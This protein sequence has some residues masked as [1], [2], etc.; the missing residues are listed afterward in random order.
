MRK[1][2]LNIAIIVAI[3]IGV[4]C[5]A[6]SFATFNNIE[7]HWAKDV[8]NDFAEKGYINSESGN[9]EPDAEINKGELT[10]ITNA[11]FDFSADSSVAENLKIAEEKGYLF[12]A[13]SE[14]K[15]TR[16]EVA[17]LICRV[18][19]ISPSIETSNSGDYLYADDSEISE[20]AKGY[21]YALKEKDIIIGYPSLEYKPQKN[22]TKAEYVT[23]LNRCIGIGGGLELV[24]TEIENIDVGIMAY[25]D[26]EIVINLIGETL[27]I[28]V[29][30]EHTVAM[31]IPEDVEEDVIF[32]I[33]DDS[34]VSYDEE[35]DVLCGLQ[36]GITKMTFKSQ[37]EK[38]EKSFEI[39]V[40]E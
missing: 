18:L 29:G 31:V 2:L 13:V 12:N 1:F 38:Y 14:E 23:V 21:V 19:S 6:I 5:S 37:D 20:W 28:N 35:L 17:I 3:F 24:D 32:E 7:N 15:I 25:E 9:F 16:E 39:V 10:V 26:G 34:I 8:I 4:T 30:D 22:I 11:Y 27:E 36:A 33:V 40:N